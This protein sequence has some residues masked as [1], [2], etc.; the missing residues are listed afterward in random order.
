M[1]FAKALSRKLGVEVMRL[2]IQVKE[3]D[4]EVETWV[5][6]YSFYGLG[7]ERKKTG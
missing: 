2:W 7:Y 4:E 3:V 6:N 5:V 1:I